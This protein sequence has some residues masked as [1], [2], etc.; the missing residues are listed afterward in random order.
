MP[1]EK[2]KNWRDTQAD[3]GKLFRKHGI[4][5]EQWSISD[6]QKRV[7][8]SFV[9]HYREK[10][11]WRREDRGM[12]VVQPARN[13]VVRLQLPLKPEGPERNQSFRVLYWLLKSKLEA[14]AFAFQDGTEFFNFEREFF[15]NVVIED[16]H[17]VA[18]E[19]FDAFKKAR[20]TLTAPERVIAL[21]GGKQ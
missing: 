6:L 8:L 20:I 4:G 10:S 16:D 14:I 3:I 1:Y 21:S 9:K 12:V 5:D 2:A 18:T 13:V 15:G 17:G 7:A 11:E 19:A